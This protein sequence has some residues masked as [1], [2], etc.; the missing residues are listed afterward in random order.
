MA[1]EQRV[2]VR[3]A[4]VRVLVTE[5]RLMNDCFPSLERVPPKCE[6]NGA[7][8]SHFA[9]P[10]SPPGNFGCLAARLVEGGE[11]HTSFYLLSLSIVLMPIRIRD[12]DAKGERGGG[13]EGG[14]ERDLLVEKST[15]LANRHMDR[16]R[17][18]SG[19]TAAQDA[20]DA[21]CTG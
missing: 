16:A 6:A 9:F 19:E 11:A 5:R 18:S 14:R 8:P 15:V 1:G 21:G 3:L 17:S 10:S 2:R 7:G 20:G 4:R 12:A 13:R